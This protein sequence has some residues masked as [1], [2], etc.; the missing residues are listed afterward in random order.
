MESKEGFIG[1]CRYVCV[2][3]L[4]PRAPMQFLFGFV[5]AFGKEGE[6]LPGT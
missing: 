2:K 5:I 4:Y 3:G 6:E 1:L